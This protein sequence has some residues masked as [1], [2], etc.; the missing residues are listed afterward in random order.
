MVPLTERI[1]TSCRAYQIMSTLTADHI[2]SVLEH[3]GVKPAHMLATSAG[4]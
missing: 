4:V 1:D 3:L 2:L